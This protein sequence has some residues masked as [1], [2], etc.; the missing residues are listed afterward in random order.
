MSND[1]C[2]HERNFEAS[3]LNH[4]TL[5]LFLFLFLFLPGGL[6]DVR[7]ISSVV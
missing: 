4:H 3:F 6:S 1:A 5:S 7:V 2:S